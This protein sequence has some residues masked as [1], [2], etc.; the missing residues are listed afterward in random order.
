[1]AIT[2]AINDLQAIERAA[3]A[4]RRGELVVL[5]TD[6]VYGLACSP[7]DAA[8]IERIYVVKQR[9]ADK[10]LPVLLADES[11]ALK[12]AREITPTA[13]KL[14]ARFWPGVLTLTLPKRADLPANLTAYATVGLRMPDHDGCRALIRAAGGVLAVTSANRS[15]EANPTTV[16]MAAASLG[17]GVAVYLDGGESANALASTVVDLRGASFTIVRAG[18]ITEAMIQAVLEG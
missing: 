9:P 11:D 17:E 1:M 10:S 15:G 7:F 16:Q 12:V 6:T 13:A 18:A 8:A 14:M 3:A 4:I 2:L 5:P